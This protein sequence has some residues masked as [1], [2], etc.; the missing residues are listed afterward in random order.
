MARAEFERIK[1]GMTH[2]QVDAVLIHWSSRRQIGHI[3]W[4][5]QEYV[6]FDGDTACIS[7]ERGAHGVTGK[8]LWESDQ[9]LSAGL[10]RL[11]LWLRL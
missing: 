11:R 2:Q 8:E 7:F 5:E 3:H 1:P 4:Y 10:K 9:S 6:N